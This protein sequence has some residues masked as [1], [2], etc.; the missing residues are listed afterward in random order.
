MNKSVTLRSNSAQERT[1]AAQARH[2]AAQR[3]GR[4]TD[5]KHLMNG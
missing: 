1:P 5:T 3:Q 4:C 2:G